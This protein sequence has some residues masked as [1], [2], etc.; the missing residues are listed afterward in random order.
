M[1][2]EESI[3]SAVKGATD[4]VIKKDGVWV[5]LVGNSKLKQPPA[6]CMPPP[7]AKAK[8]GGRK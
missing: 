2:Y 8:I 5:R 3:L 7:P 4:I 1:S 6:P